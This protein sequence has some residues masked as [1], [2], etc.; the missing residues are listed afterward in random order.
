MDRALTVGS[1]LTGYLPV[2]PLLTCSGIDA[3]YGPVQILFGVDFAVAP[4]EIVALLGTN[5]AGKSTLLKVASG[6][7]TPP[8]VGCGW[9]ATTS[10]GRAPT[11]CPPT[12][13]PAGGSR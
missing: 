1:N 6:L 9:T 2:E 3:S 4:G 13:S 5:G 8:P 10:P 12:P 7:L 11:T